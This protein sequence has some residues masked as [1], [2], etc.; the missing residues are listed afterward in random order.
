MNI[1]FLSKFCVLIK[2]E[3]LQ[4]QKW[5]GGQEPQ[6]NKE[7]RP[8]TKIDGCEGQRSNGIYSQ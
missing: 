5:N 2:H 1:V 8:G 4:A 3:N 6:E 7:N